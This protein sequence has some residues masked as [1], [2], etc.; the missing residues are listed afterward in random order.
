MPP[1]YILASRFRYALLNAPAMRAAS[2]VSETLG[3][4]QA[5]LDEAASMSAPADVKEATQSA[6]E[7]AADTVEVASDVYSAG[8]AEGSVS[9]PVGGTSAEAPAA[10]GEPA[11]PE[12]P[13]G[14]TLL[15]SVYS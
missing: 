8:Q 15:P 9:A 11:Q 4:Y 3:A 12:A 6:K 1:R 7:A 14:P 5:A 2:S 10:A 13:A